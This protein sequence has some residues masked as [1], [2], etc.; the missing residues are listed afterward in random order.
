MKAILNC[1]LLTFMLLA[2]SAINIAA[3]TPV[4][5]TNPGFE[6]GANGWTLPS[7]FTVVNDT[8]HTGTHSLRLQNTN[9]GVYQLASQD[10]KV[11]RD[12]MYH[13]AVWVK[14]AGV[15]G[16]DTGATLCLE[17]WDKNG[18]YLGGGYPNGIKGDNDW[19]MVQ[20]DTSLVPPKAAKVALT[21]YL[22]KTM[23]GTA[24][25]DDVTIKP[26][27][28]TPVDFALVKP[29]YR[30]VIEANSN[31]QQVLIY[32]KPASIFE[33]GI[34]LNKT[35]LVCRVLTGGQAV[36]ET[37]KRPQP[38]INEIS[39]SAK[40]LPVGDYIVEVSIADS[41]GRVFG[42]KTTQL[43]KTTAG[44]S[45]P[46][47]YIDQYGRTIRNGKPFF[48]LGMY[49]GPGP[50]L[51]GSYKSHID[52]ISS[53]AFNTIM[54]YGINT[55]SMPAIRE[56]LDYLQSKNVS[57]LYSLKDIFKGV[58]YYE[59]NMLGLGDEDGQINGIVSAFRD[60][61]AVL[62][63]YL[64]DETPLTYQNRLIKRYQQVKTLDPNH[65]T[66]TVVCDP[67]AFFGYL[68]T[69]DVLG[70]DP[71]PINYSTVDMASTWTQ[72]TVGASG[73]HKAVWMVPQAHNLGLYAQTP[74]YRAP[75]M[76]EMM[77]M[78]Y[79]CLIDGAKGLIYYSYF[80][81]QRDS[82]GF[83]VRWRDMATVGQEMK[84]LSPAILSIKRAPKITIDRDKKTIFNR[85]MSDDQGKT[86]ILLANRSSKKTASAVI[87]VPD[88]RKALLIKNSKQADIT[89]EIMNG[90]LT[91]KLSPI[92][93]CTV[94]LG[95]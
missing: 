64:N 27:Y 23:T 13:I 12:I 76:D 37:S 88:G 57:I 32:A 20:G 54:P 30:G 67:T 4:N 90:K 41:S 83:D 9:P 95:R 21:L 11:D 84:M 36:L 50:A 56:Y 55:V 92:K 31:D 59:E 47:T 10:L 19:T 87:S 70:S 89:S 63:W 43:H 77:V 80:D 3:Q 86:Y 79:L 75:T 93:A 69:C 6:D 2:L 22:R 25:F 1:A 65:P 78:S 7:N 74:E 40:K 82:L 85:I 51:D 29:P 91:I 62:G 94:V 46:S 18:T 17:Y 24:W 61:P 58:A 15:T 81:L 35:R 49:F 5:I 26:Y 52:R 44:S 72:G 8:A 42:S 33:S 68:E 45:K 71:Y 14:T 34:R 60:H 48:P 16:T 53:S 66:W 28:G 73:G 39:F 38:G